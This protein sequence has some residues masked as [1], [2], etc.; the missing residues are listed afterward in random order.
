MDESALLS[1]LQSLEASW[2][3]LEFWLGVCATL[4]VLGVIIEVFVVIRD[5]RQDWREFRRGTIH[6]PD[7][8]SVSTVVWGLFGSA[9]VAIGVFGELLVGIKAGK[10]ET[11][12]R[13]TTDRLVAVIDEK[14]KSADDFAKSFESQIA[15]ANARAKS[16]EAQVA[17]ANAASHEAVAKVAE[18]NSKAESFRLQIAQANERAASAEERAVK[19]EKQLEWRRVTPSEAESICATVGVFAGTKMV[20]E[21]IAGDLEGAQYAD[22]FGETLRSKNCGWDVTVTQIM[23]TSRGPV[24]QVP[25]GLSILS[26][27]LYNP[28]AAALQAVLNSLGLTTSGQKTG[29]V[30]PGFSFA[31][32]VGLKPRPTSIKQTS[33]LDE[34]RR[35]QRNNFKTGPHTKGARRTA[36]P[37]LPQTKSP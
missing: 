37:H 19:L 3:S 22:D 32:D 23:V 26:P 29:A 34:P 12:M 11:Q 9:L 2:S 21:S 1:S 24:S 10:V 20:V 6:S 8:P 25:Q 30:P 14:A 7:K 33:K 28:P 15:S 17:S 16:A 27:D 13:G 31:L 35:H 5:W 36:A 18:A 4:V